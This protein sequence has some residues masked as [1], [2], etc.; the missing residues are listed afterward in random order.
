MLMFKSDLCQTILLEAY[1]CNWFCLSGLF[2]KYVIGEVNAKEFYLLLYLIALRA[3]SH[4]TNHSLSPCMLCCNEPI[5]S[6][7]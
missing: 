4:S 2:H 7:I 3:L 6:N 1:P 5:N